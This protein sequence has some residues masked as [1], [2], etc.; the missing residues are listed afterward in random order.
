MLVYVFKEWVCVRLCEIVW[1][2]VRLCEII[3]FD[4]KEGDLGFKYEIFKV[5]WVDWYV[6]FGDSNVFVEK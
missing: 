3:F 4:C 1:D 6:I 5:L 2:Y